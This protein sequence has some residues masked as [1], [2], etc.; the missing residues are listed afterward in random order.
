[1]VIKVLGRILAYSA[2]GT[3]HN[4]TASLVALAFA[5]CPDLPLSLAVFDMGKLGSFLPLPP[6]QS[7]ALHL[8]FAT[9]IS[10]RHTVSFLI[11]GQ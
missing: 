10:L 3:H 2:F 4:M 9:V 11:F 1:M 5:L 7:M 6:L 8:M